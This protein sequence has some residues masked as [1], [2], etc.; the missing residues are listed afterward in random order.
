MSDN[1]SEECGIIGITVETAK[2]DVIKNIYL[3]LFSLQHRGQ[4]SCGIAYYFNDK[5]NLL[6]RQGLVSDTLF[7]DL[8]FDLKISSAIGHVR[9]STCG[10]SNLK[11]AQ[12][13]L[14]NCNKGEIALA[15]NGNIPNAIKIK[16][17]LIESGS[18]FQTTS[19]SEILI[20]LLARNN[21]KDFKS[22][23]IE[24]IKQLK[25]AF[26]ILMLYKNSI[27]AF[28]DPF[29]FRPLCIGKIKNGYVFASETCSFDIIGADFVRE[30]KPGEIVFCKG[31]KL[32][33]F[34]Y[35]DSTSIRQCIFELIYFARP[36]SI[37]FGESVH[38]V[39]L[40]LGEKLAERNLNL[41]LVIP[42]PDSGNSAALGFSK[43]AKIPFDFGLIR[44][45][46]TGRTFIKPGQTKREEGV[47]VKL[48]PIKSVIKDKKIAIIDDSLVRGT[49]SSKIVNMLKNAG[50]KEVHLFLSSPEIKYSCYY[51]I[52]T[53]TRE[54]LL[55][56][57]YSSKEIAKIIG[58][59]SVNFLDIEDLKKCV[60]E[61]EKF[62]YACFNG[63]YPI[64]VN[65]KKLC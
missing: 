5:I 45:H 54:E 2:D 55:S 19:D 4:E 13:F 53:P 35:F 40:K 20:H 34:Q 42:V 61:P 7:K 9:Y 46:Y 39:R 30:I 41:D 58:A 15:H 29:G 24:V 63:E 44:N 47:K 12:P 57:K 65:D 33:S 51:G 26:S 48:N 31:E 17:E 6:T 59:D 27:V 60:K 22:S 64:P 18:I 37:I 36:D 49:T 1:F 38:Q 56:S 32:E 3:G 62:C 21:K 11:N 14:F 25:G 50:A 16:N 23:L 8:P 43:A 52:D 10:E 28:R